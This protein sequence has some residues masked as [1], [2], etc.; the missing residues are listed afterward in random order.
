MVFSLKSLTMFRLFVSVNSQLVSSLFDTN[1][2]SIE[3]VKDS[4][5]KPVN[6][7]YHVWVARWINPGNHNEKLHVVYDGESPADYPGNPENF[8]VAGWDYDRKEDE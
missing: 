7:F 6:C 8:S 5:D 2:I 1:I 4:D 3:S